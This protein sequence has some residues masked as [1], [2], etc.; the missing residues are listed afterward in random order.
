LVPYEYYPHFVSL[1]E[2]ESEEWKTRSRVI[3]REMAIEGGGDT[4]TAGTFSQRLKLLLIQRARIAKKASGKL[5]L[6]V[7]LLTTEYR[8]GQSWLVYCED[9]SQL[10]ALKL[11][12][13]S[14]GLPVDEY[15]TDMSGDP[16]TTLQWFRRYGGVL[17]SVRCLDE[18]IDIPSV[19]HALILASSQNPREFIQRRGRVLRVDPNNP[20]K[21]QAIIYD[22]LVLPEDL[23][24]E[25]DQM[26]LV[27]SELARAVEFARGALNRNAEIDLLAKAI[28]IGLD[29]ELVAGVG[30]EED[31]DERTT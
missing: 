1:T 18:G 29:P 7:R 8:Q 6:A 27:K 4:G 3:R 22:A 10:R 13:I 30:L 2:E 5:P 20:G 28:A 16:E 25:P 17:V 9:I 19:S 24:Q 31:D 21:T 11:Q 26:S 12:L 15:N 14:A 23:A